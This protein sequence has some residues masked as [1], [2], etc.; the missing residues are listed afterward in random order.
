MKTDHQTKVKESKMQTMQRTL[1]LKRVMV[2][3]EKRLFDRRIRDEENDYFRKRKMRDEIDQGKRQFIRMKFESQRIIENQQR[4]N[5]LLLQEE[6]NNRINQINE[7]VSSSSDHS[8]THCDCRFNKWK[9]LRS[10]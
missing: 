3:E 7:K 6:R 8:L 1:G 9:T 5:Y 4:Q 10:C 2:S